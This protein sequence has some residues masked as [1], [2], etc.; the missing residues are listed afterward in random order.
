MSREL[1]LITGPD[2]L[3]RRQPVPIVSNHRDMNIMLAFGSG[4]RGQSCQSRKKSP[5][6]K[7]V[8]TATYADGIYP[9]AFG[10]GLPNP[11]H[12]SAVARDLIHDKAARHDQGIKSQRISRHTPS[13]CRSGRVIS[14]AARLRAIDNVIVYRGQPKI[15]L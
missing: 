11:T 4:R 5:S 15:L 6:S 8:E 7:T 2:G 13:L 14:S 10:S 12:E 1:N 9:S 3:I